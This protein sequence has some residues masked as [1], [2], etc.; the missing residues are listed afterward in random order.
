MRS[1]FRTQR[2]TLNVYR[3]SGAGAEE[4]HT[5]SW[6]DNRDAACDCTVER[7]GSGGRTGDGGAARRI[8]HESGLVL[9]AGS[10][11]RQRRQSPTAARLGSAGAR[12]CGSLARMAGKGLG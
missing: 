10:G 6:E 12:P 11:C 5:C 7:I 9:V 8:G 1:K 4:Q 2:S 3:L